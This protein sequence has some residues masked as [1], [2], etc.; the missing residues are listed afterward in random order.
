M[1]L[2]P[3]QLKVLLKL[4]NIY[5][6]IAAPLISEEELDAVE[7]IKYLVTKEIESNDSN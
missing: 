1:N 6:P 4:L 2:T 7:H 5:I 3:F